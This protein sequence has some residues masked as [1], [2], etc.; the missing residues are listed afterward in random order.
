MFLSDFLFLGILLVHLK[1]TIQSDT[2][3]F[4]SYQMSFNRFFRNYDLKKDFQESEYHICIKIIKCNL[5]I[6]I[7]YCL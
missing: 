5:C 2:Y 4:I 6:N 7:I 3:F 1:M